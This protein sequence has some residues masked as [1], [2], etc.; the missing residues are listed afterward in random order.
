M[1]LT[2][3]PRGQVLHHDPVSPLA[4]WR[5]E[6]T[7]VSPLA[8][9]IAQV[10]GQRRRRSRRATALVLRAGRARTRPARAE[11][12]RRLGGA[13]GEDQLVGLAAERPPATSRPRPLDERARGAPLGMDRGRVARR[14]PW[15]RPSP[16]APR[17]AAAPSRSGRDRRA[18]LIRPRAPAGP[19]TAGHGR[20][21]V[22]HH[23]ATGAS[24]AGRRRHGAESPP[25]GGSVIDCALRAR[26]PALGGG[27]LVQRAHRLVHGAEDLGHA[28]RRGRA[29]QPVA[30]AGPARDS[31]SPSRRSLTKSCSR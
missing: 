26:R 19:G 1:S 28:D 17:G 14:G 30:A 20:Q 10:H 25:T 29:R 24:G 27:A 13:G 4:S 5:S 15:P 8:R 31:T 7:P 6:T 12:A 16:P 23:V 18:A 2:A 21:L 11:H 3:R 9:P 22:P